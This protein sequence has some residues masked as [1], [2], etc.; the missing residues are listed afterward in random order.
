M[1]SENSVS[2][3]LQNNTS[4]THPHRHATSPTEPGRR[5]LIQVSQS[6]PT[7]PAHNTHTPKTLNSFPAPSIC[8]ASPS[9]KPTHTIKGWKLCT[10]HA[11]A[12]AGAVTHEV[13]FCLSLFPSPETHQTFGM[14]QG[15]PQTPAFEDSDIPSR[16]QAKTVLELPIQQQ[17]GSAP[18][19]NPV[20]TR[21]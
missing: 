18:G 8:C 7:H 20:I 15:A 21:F 9:P 12:A 2:S 13:C 11:G 5:T 19:R 4:T 16:A 1:T 14:D 6:K 10:K 17:V 3:M